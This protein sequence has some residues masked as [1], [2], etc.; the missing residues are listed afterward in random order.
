[1][2]EEK[3]P[4]PEQSPDAHAQAPQSEPA[5]AAPGTIKLS[6]SPTMVLGVLAGLLIISLI[7][8][9]LNRGGSQDPAVRELQAK[10]DDM[11][12]QLNRERIAMGLSPLDSQGDSI[13]DVAGRMKKD[14][15]LMVSMAAN[16][17]NMLLEKEARI[18]ARTAEFNRSEQLREALAAESVR[19]QADLQRALVAVSEVESLR[20]EHADMKSQ[21]DA[22]VTELAAVRQQLSEKSGGV[23]PEEY[24]HLMRQLEE[25]QRARDF[26]EARASSLESQ[27]KQAALFAKNDNELLP[28]AVEL[29]ARLRKLEGKTEAEIDSAYSSLGRELGASVLH[30]FSF[31]TGSSTLSVEDEGA[32]RRLSSE[33]PDGDL[34][35]IIGYA[36][37]TG[38]VDL[39]RT[40][41]SDRATHA[42]EFYTSI[43][44]PGQLVQG[45]Y[46]GQTDRFSSTIHER[47][48]IVE[49]WQIPKK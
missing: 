43:K 11:R 47:N 22:L 13:N 41:S 1:M 30:N 16:Y 28:A 23:S 17:Q 15:D 21:R 24:Q 9:V 8:L 18:T 25:T 44:R 48:Q 42:A 49:L 20:R 27:L 40:L 34:L 46:L 36:S 39:N 4:P 19:L 2:S 29:F 14:A 45:V 37:E 7:I 10:A 35:F 38:N 32:L 26:F 5:T 12:Q 6:I 3:S 33:I 31:T